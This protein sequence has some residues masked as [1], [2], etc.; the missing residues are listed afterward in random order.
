MWS[1]YTHNPAS[2]VSIPLKAA[3]ALGLDDTALANQ[4]GVDVTL[5]SG[6]ATV[7]GPP[8]ALLRVADRAE[9]RADPRGGFS[10]TSSERASLRKAVKRLRAGARS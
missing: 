7:S 1:K 10:H 6:T 2:G 3:V 5:R 9:D 4:Y 8:N